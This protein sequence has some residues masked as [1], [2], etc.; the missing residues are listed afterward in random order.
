MRLSILTI[1]SLILLV[2]VAIPLVLRSRTDSA[3]IVYAAPTCRLPLE[4]IA[5]KY[6]QETKI[7]VEL[8]I[9]PS[10]DLLTKV[11]LPNPQRPGDLF[12]P[13][14]DSYIHLAEELNLISES[15]PIAK[16]HGVLLLTKENIRGISCWNDLTRQGVKVAVPNMGAAIG[17]VSR[18]HLMAHGRWQAIEPHVHDC[19]SVTE[20]A[21]ATKIGSVDA[22]I[23]WDAVAAGTAYKDQKV[24]RPPELNGVRGRV[25]V[26]VLRQSRDM[27][28]AQQFAKYIV[29]PNHGLVQF[30]DAGFLI[31]V[32]EMKK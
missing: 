21:N 2:C 20:G 10:E 18:E 16:I 3:L 14:D 4:Q 6:E 22:A 32:A 5:A 7:H 9:S 24:L 1:G 30:R 15:F 13:A 19:L 17:K 31:D 8:Q 28:A 26:A 11:R 23:V 25:Q 12:I 27:N 29:D